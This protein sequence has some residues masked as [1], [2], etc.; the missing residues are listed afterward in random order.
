MN[1]RLL[2]LLKQHESEDH[3]F[4]ETLDKDAITRTTCA[5]LNSVGGRIV[6]GAN[7]RGEII[8][9]RNRR[10]A[11]Q[12]EDI[13]R[14]AVLPRAMWTVTLE[15][16]D[17]G[18]L[19]V[20]DVPKGMSKPY[21]LNGA[22]WYRDG[23]TTRPA[24]PDDVS[25]IIKDRA[26]AD[27]RWERRPALGVTDRDIDL[28]EVRKA[29][30]DI[31]SRGRHQFE[32][33]SNAISVLNELSLYSAEQ[34]TNAAVVLFGKNPSRVFPQ[35]VV[36]VTV[37]KKSKTDSE[38]LLDKRFEGHLFS[39][40]REIVEVVELRVDVSS[41]FQ[42]GEWQRQDKPSYPLWSLREGILNALVH[43][44][45]S[46]PSGGMSIAIYPNRIKVW[47]SGS[48]PSGWDVDDL[49]VDHPSI[50]PNPDIAHVCFL[51][52]LIEKLGRGTQLIVEEY[53]NAGLEIPE[54]KSSAKG[55]EL[56]FKNVAGS[57]QAAIMNLSQ[58]QREIVS[59]LKPGQ[60][61]TVSEYVEATG[62]SITERTARTDLN[63]LIKSGL[64]TKH[65]RGKNT[66]Y[67][68]SDRAV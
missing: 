38:Y 44:D 50:P 52:G 54:W 3:E 2:N 28:N 25:Q 39:T 16:T 30:K 21:L 56:V 4:F 57:R 8:G 26:L 53:E 37:Y 47:N 24:T 68:R 36:R 40:F 18:R 22:I 41:E 34:F 19:L 43:R 32:K 15:E 55:V 7:E 20:I 45:L 1:E 29:A 17:E 11:K 49:R 65:G 5:F 51:R 46:S 14:L 27:E 62:D 67:V 13:L 61:F 48:L 9:L 31:Q 58:R 42:H 12:V 33:P 59:T 63:G 35:S 6:V 60:E 66:Y 64:V 23:A 10:P